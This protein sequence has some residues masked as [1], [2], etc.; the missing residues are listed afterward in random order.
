M[1]ASNTLHN[2]LN[3]LPPYETPKLA[4]AVESLTPEQIDR[5]PFGVTLLDANNVIRLLNKTEAESSGFGNRVTVGR[6]FFVDVAPCMN[7]SYVR[8]RIEKAR[9]AGVLDIIFTF[10]GDFSDSDRELTVR[11]QSGRDGA[12]W[13]FIQRA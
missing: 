9:Q 3:S 13:I 6:L 7:N 5:L 8:G 4:A 1:K 2:Q 11:A 12:L 10:V